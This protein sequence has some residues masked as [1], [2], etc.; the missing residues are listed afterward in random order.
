M[1]LEL[2]KKP[3]PPVLRHERHSW[4]A[5]PEQVPQLASHGAQSDEP[6]AYL[7]T[8]VQSARQ[9]WHGSSGISP[10]ASATQP[11]RLLAKGW[12]VAQLVQSV[13]E[14][15]VH[16]S[17]LAWHAAH[18][19]AAELVPPEQ[20]DPGSMAQLASQPSPATSLPSSHVSEPT[21]RPSPHTLAHVSLLPRLPPLHTYPSSTP[22]VLLQPSPAAVLLSSQPSSPRTA[23][24]IPSPHDGAH[25]SSPPTPLPPSSCVEL[26]HAKPSSSWHSASQPSPPTVLLSSHASADER[27]PLP[28]TC[29]T[30]VTVKLS[31]AVALPVSSSSAAEAAQPA[32]AAAR[33]RRGV[34][35]ECRLR[36]R[37][38]RVACGVEAHLPLARGSSVGTE[39]L[40]FAH[41]VECHQRGG[42]CGGRGVMRQQGRHCSVKLECEV[43]RQR[44]N[45]Q[46]G[47]GHADC[48]LRELEATRRRAL[49]QRGNLGELG[50]G[51]GAHVELEKRENAL[52]E[53]RRHKAAVVKAH[54]QHEIGPGG[55]QSGRRRR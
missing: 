33:E 22:H 23:S 35:I 27:T 44:A 31:V 14:P 4:A 51:H 32:A 47:A 16:V 21:R 38:R 18:V 48:L 40:Y 8:G 49:L 50:V 36:P 6:L 2:A 29:T 30:G 52:V 5:G 24:E 55:R 53:R 20:V 39:D 1:Q 41:R 11:S 43:A 25:V 19:S 15:P 46:G 13:Y 42:E 7:P 17:Q 3:R 12:A 10:S 45:L 54:L 9:R 26:L 37:V 28:Q 34:D